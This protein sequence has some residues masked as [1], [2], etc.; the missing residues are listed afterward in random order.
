ME[1]LFKKFKAD[2]LSP[3]ELAR[4]RDELNRMSDDDIQELINRAYGNATDT[5]DDTITEERLTAMKRIIDIRNGHK[6]THVRIPRYLLRISAA[7]AILIVA[8]GIYFYIKSARFGEYRQALVR[9][10]VI[11][12]QRGERAT[13][14]LPD[15][16]TVTLSGNS[17]ISY[18][19]SC[20]N[21]HSR[22]VS[23]SGNALFNVTRDDNAPFFISAADDL[24]V[25]VLGTLFFLSTHSIRHSSQLYL[26]RGAVQI[27]SPKLK[28]NIDLAPHQL[29]TFNTSDGSYTIT[30]VANI[31]ESE[32]RL[33][34]DIIASS[35]PISEVASRLS[36]LYDRRFDIRP[37][38]ADDYFTGY[39]PGD[40]LEDVINILGHSYKV[41]VH[42]NSDTISID[43]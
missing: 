30:D 2:R 29:I 26:E 39:L 19:L 25:K 8:A 10:N 7:A 11:S 31:T 40:N 38:V 13:A 4:F 5:P 24:E 41:T 20:F 16:T 18:S 37:R 23:L 6:P 14:I 27:Y 42:E 35:E 32:A 28:H 9:E 36:M 1:S 43:L 15:G 34:G 22:R 3:E 33:R 12:V 17:S 21:S